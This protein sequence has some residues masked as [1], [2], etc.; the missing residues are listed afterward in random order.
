MTD[1]SPAGRVGTADEVAAVAA[2]LLGPDA[3]FI[4]GTDLLMDGGVIAALRGGRWQLSRWAHPP[5][6]ARGNT[7]QAPKKAPE[8]KTMKQRTLG[9]NGLTVSEI[10]LG[11]MSLTGAYG[12]TGEVSRDD[13]VALIRHAVDIC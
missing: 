5:K 4:T 2:F 3:G 6:P 1:P 10:G 9:S 11:C 8:R 7:H 12:N 13:A